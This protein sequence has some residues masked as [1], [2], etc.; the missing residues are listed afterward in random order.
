MIRRTKATSLL[1]REKG[2]GKKYGSIPFPIE[3]PTNRT[4][5]YN[6]CHCLPQAHKTITT[7]AP[8]ND[9]TCRP[10]QQIEPDRTGKS[11]TDQETHLSPRLK[12][13]SPEMPGCG[14][15]HRHVVKVIDGQRGRGRGVCCYTAQKRKDAAASPPPPRCLRPGVLETCRF[16]LFLEQ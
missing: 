14:L 7:I 11:T 2:K 16:C 3:G 8:K 9:Q 1:Q 4:K 5:F 10:H 12:P 15:R 6:Q 13:D